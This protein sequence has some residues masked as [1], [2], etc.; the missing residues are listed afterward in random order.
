MKSQ[1][2][3]PN[4][5][6]ADH[7]KNDIVHLLK[8]RGEGNLYLGFSGELESRYVEYAHNRFG[9]INFTYPFL[10]AFGMLLFLFSDY[11]VAPAGMWSFFW[12][13][14][15]GV[16]IVIGFTL[17]LRRDRRS[18]SAIKNHH[19][20]HLV[21]SLGTLLLHFL[22]LFIGAIAA[23]H[24]E[25]HYQTGS[26]ILIVLYCTVV[27]VDFR[28]TAPTTLVICLTQLAFSYLYLKDHSVVVEH[29]FM[30]TTIALFS[31]L[32][33]GRMEHETRKTYLQ[34]QLILLE[35]QQLEEAKQ[36]L[37]LMSISDPLTG[38]TN[39]RGFDLQMPKVWSFCLRS[40]KPLTLLIIDV[41]YFKQY[42]DTLGHP[43][44]DE[45]LKQVGHLILQSGRRPED[46]VARLGGEEFVIVLPHTDREAAEAAAEILRQRVVSLAIPHPSS[47]LSLLTVSIGLANSL[48]TAMNTFE[49]L[50]EEA[51]ANLYEAKRAG[52]NQV[53]PKRHGQPNT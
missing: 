11:Q 18:V 37:Y 8:T 15:T 27:R 20:D 45:A 19:L 13:R 24:G 23:N 3:C 9:K 36:Q 25:L 17:V 30:F 31:C 2:H 21:I 47:P 26:L 5:G 33:N 32:A 10:G 43:A 53:W 46:I 52:R 12:A 1:R 50:F 42:N 22:L 41:D 35:Q 40:G 51:D 7:L 29:G 34:E 49:S 38:L 28:Y 16:A 4:T 39:R 14:V 6:M 48:P 44:G